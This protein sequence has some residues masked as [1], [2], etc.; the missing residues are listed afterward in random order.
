[1]YDW[2]LLLCEG[3]INLEQPSSH[4]HIPETEQQ[5]SVKHDNIRVTFI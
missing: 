2:D 4:V 1:M 3:D 5:K